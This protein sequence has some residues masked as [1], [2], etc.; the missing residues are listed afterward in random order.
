MR[1]SLHSRSIKY[2]HVC[3]SLGIFLVFPNYEF[4]CDLLE[5]GEEKLYNLHFNTNSLSLYFSASFPSVLSHRGCKLFSSH[6]CCR[7]IGCSAVV[8]VRIATISIV[9]LHRRPAKM[10]LHFHM[11]T[12][13]VEGGRGS[14]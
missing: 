13:G 2:R 8:L 14:N 6:C 7:N 3:N 5:E 12:H 4:R 1:E 9:A 10:K 11:H